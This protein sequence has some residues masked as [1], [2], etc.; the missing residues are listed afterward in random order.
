LTWN[1]IRKVLST[2]SKNQVRHLLMG[3][4]AC[5]LYGGAEFSRDTDV[6]ILADSANLARLTVSLQELQAECIAVPPFESAYL[7]RGHAIHF[8]CHHPDAD[9][10]RLDVMAVMRGVAP[11]NEL[12]QRRTTLEDDTGLV[13]NVLALP[14]LVVA[15]KTQRGKDWPMIQR[16]VEANYAQFRQSPTAEQISFWFKE[17]RT[18]S[19]L[20]RL[21]AKYPDQFEAACRE[22]PLLAHAAAASERALAAAI[23]DE[24]RQEQEAD[25]LYWEPLRQ[26]LES[27][28]R[29]RRNQ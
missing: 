17:L 13:L 26:E 23:A 19:L 14:D 20:I 5:V 29:Q 12:W 15:K 8:R 2:L 27:L 9:R 25:R 3:G 24:Q 28:R 7:E 4:Q 21:A 10:M 6:A 16:L 11:F 22:R 18:P 1:P